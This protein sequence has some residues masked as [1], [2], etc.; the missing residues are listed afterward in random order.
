MRKKICYLGA[1]AAVLASCTVKEPLVPETPVVNPV[2]K[3]DSVLLDFG[4][5]VNRGIATK[6]GAVGEL[7][8]NNGGTQLIDTGFGV[9]AYYNNGELYNDMARPD[10]MYNQQL[11]YDGAN[12]VYSPLRY[13]PNEFGSN[14]AS[15]EVDRLT[16]FAYAPWVKVTPS[17]G[18]LLG[19]TDDENDPSQSTQTGI[20]GMSRNTASGSPLIKYASSLNADNCVDLCWG[21]AKD[22]FTSSVDG[23]N[24]N[25]NPGKP[26]IDVIKP[27]IGDK[28]KFD[29]KHA[30]AALNVQIDAVMDAENIGDSDELD[31]FTHIYVRSITFEGFTTKGALDLNSD[32]TSTSTTPNWFDLAGTGKL[33]LEPIIVYDGRRDGKEGVSSAIAKNETPA[34]LNPDIVQSTAYQ[35]TMDGDGFQFANVVGLTPG[36]T[37]TAV[38]LFKSSSS[39][40][41]VYVIPTEEAIKVTIVYDVETA[42]NTLSGYLSDGETHGTSVENAITKE[43]TLSSGAP[44]KLDAGKRY[45]IKLHLG[46]TSVKFDADVYEWENDTNYGEPDLPYNTETRIGSNTTLNYDASAADISFMMS[47]LTN[48]STVSVTSDPALTITT[49]YLN[50]PDEKVNAGGRVK[51][52]ASLPANDS[53]A[54]KSYVLTITENLQAGG[55][56]VSTITL[57]QG[58]E[59]IAALGENKTL[60]AGAEAATV[61]FVLSGLTDGAALTATS[62][63]INP[64]DVTIGSISGGRAMVSIPV[65]LNTTGEEKNTVVTISDGTS[66]SDITIVQEPIAFTAGPDGALSAATEFTWPE[67]ISADG[68]TV[69]FILKGLTLNRTLELN[70]ESGA[71]DFAGQSKAAVMGDLVIE[72]SGSAPT[73]IGTD[74]CAKVTVSLKARGASATTA[75]TLVL[76][77]SQRGANGNDL[78]QHTKISFV[79]NGR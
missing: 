52:S 59:V 1:L 62:S 8:Y 13:W 2:A 40:A 76:C 39:N 17:T 68:E 77:F 64:S 65:S 9:F 43:I 14:A 71:S 50:G 58:T 73:K 20:I 75:R 7:S 32:Y 51:F 25:V 67:N 28:I 42:D 29:F 10:F 24:N 55:T 11:S 23:D 53:G 78:K 45:V 26:Y 19:Y 18:I 22:A 49:Y 3:A 72:T 61:S 74:R 47:G 6:A 38:N 37:K 27:K 30:L 34:D 5:Y 36:V 63:D 70:T 56:K 46:L 31:S 15:E 44:M 35:T 4:A 69:S 66:S 12:W 48:E 33:S 54:E 57:T 60:M 79:E 41:P 16:F 21:V